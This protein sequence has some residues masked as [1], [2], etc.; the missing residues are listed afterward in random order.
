MRFM[1]LGILM[2]GLCACAS[3]N[4]PAVSIPLTDASANITIYGSDGTTIDHTAGGWLIRAPTGESAPM[5]TGYLWDDPRPLLHHLTI[6]SNPDIAGLS[7]TRSISFNETGT[8]LLDGAKGT[9]TEVGIEKI[10][11][12]AGTF[13]AIHLVRSDLSH[14][15]NC[16][17]YRFRAIQDVWYVNGLG[18]IRYDADIHGQI[19]GT[20]HWQAVRIE[21]H[22]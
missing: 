14:C 9:V 3:T 19:P 20:V 11:V 15:L 5:M 8:T 13:M 18:P 1:V 7:T 6:M 17:S 4:Q 22:G 10:T 12:P 2:L 21:H 16:G